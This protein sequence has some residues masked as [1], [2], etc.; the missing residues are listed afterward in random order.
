MAMPLPALELAN[1]PTVAV[2]DKLEVSPVIRPVAMT[3]VPVN[4]ASLPMSYT[5]L[6]AD[7]PLII[8]GARVISLVVLAT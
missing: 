2:P 6:E 8:T 4:T 1:V 7:K 3:G 5:L